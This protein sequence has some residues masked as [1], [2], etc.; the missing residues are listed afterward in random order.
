MGKAILKELK[1]KNKFLFKYYT[2]WKDNSPKDRPT[3][4]IFKEPYLNLIQALWIY[5]KYFIRI[6]MEEA[7]HLGHY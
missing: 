6:Y 3:I 4:Y 2:T 1:I 7:H 5:L